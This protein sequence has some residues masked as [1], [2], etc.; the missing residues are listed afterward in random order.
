VSI[1]GFSISPD[2]AYP[3]GVLAGLG[4]NVEISRVNISNSRISSG[5]DGAIGGLIGQIS[6]STRPVNLVYNLIQGV[7]LRTSKPGNPVAGFV[8]VF[9]QEYYDHV[10]SN[11]LVEVTLDL[12]QRT[13]CSGGFVGYTSQGILR[14]NSVRVR[15]SYPGDYERAGGFLGCTEFGQA[16]SVLQI[17]SNRIEFDTL[18]GNSFGRVG[19]IVGALE[20]TG[21]VDL[22]S[23]WV[24]GRVDATHPETKGMLIGHYHSGNLR[25]SDN[26]WNADTCSLP[27]IQSSN[28][29]T[30]PTSNTGV[31]VADAQVG[32][33][34]SG[35]EWGNPSVWNFTAGS[36]P[37]LANLPR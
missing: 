27:A 37:D 11:N 1:S 2:S 16:S 36:L 34:F 19:G 9:Y 35:G 14:E 18:F 7:N 5:Y 33:P 6:S 31:T 20:G 24:D 8:G 26:Y 28:G 17:A 12:T 3:A 25:V 32:T 21:S 15:F 29:Y 13:Y 23:N 22:I 10:L 30:L 4:T